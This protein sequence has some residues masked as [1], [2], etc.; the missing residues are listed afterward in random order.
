MCG[1]CACACVHASAQKEVVESHNRFSFVLNVLNFVDSE[2]IVLYKANVP[3][4]LA[5]GEQ[6]C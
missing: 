6:V 1:A 2:L 5:F 4:I 3:I